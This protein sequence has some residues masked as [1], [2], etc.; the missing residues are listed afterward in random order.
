[1]T[2]YVATVSTARCF[3]VDK[4]LYINSKATPLPP[5]KLCYYYMYTKV[6]KVCAA[7]TQIRVHM[8]DGV[9]H[10]CN[11]YQMSNPH[12]IG[13]KYRVCFCAYVCS[14]NC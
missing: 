1:M 14:S 6:R 10:T 4:S 8:Y 2:V 5:S 11:G 3:T 13:S 12:W 7:W 9:L